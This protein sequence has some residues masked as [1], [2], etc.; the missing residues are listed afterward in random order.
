[1][2]P[3]SNSCGCSPPA[4]TTMTLTLGATYIGLTLS[5]GPKSLTSRRQGNVNQLQ[6]RKALENAVE[7]SVNVAARLRL[8]SQG[9]V[10]PRAKNTNR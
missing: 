4:L 8:K 3:L 1:M 6:T 5:A 10:M 2:R 7:P 9:E